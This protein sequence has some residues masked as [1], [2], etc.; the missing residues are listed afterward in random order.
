LNELGLPETT[1][2]DSKTPFNNARIRVAEPYN[3]VRQLPT[4]TADESLI[5]TLNKLRPDE[6][7]IGSEKY[8]K[9]I[10]AIIDDAVAFRNDNNMGLDKPNYGMQDNAPI[11]QQYHVALFGDES[12]I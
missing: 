7:I 8:A 1:Q 5:S 12:K 9:G 6:A 4:M 3:Q 10:N 11:P 2:F